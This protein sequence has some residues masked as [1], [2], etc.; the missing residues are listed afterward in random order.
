MIPRSQALEWLESLDAPIILAPPS[1]PGQIVQ[2][3]VPNNDG[4]EV[5]DRQDRLTGKTSRPTLMLDS[6]EIHYLWLVNDDCPQA[7]E[8]IRA[9][10]FLSCL[11]WGVDMAYADGQI[12]DDEQVSML[13]GVRWLP[14]PGTLRDDGLLRIPVGGSMID[15][16]RAHGSFLDRIEHGKP[17]RIVDKPQ[18]FDR[19][20]Y[21]SEERPL[22]RPFAVFAL[23]TIGDDSYRYAHAKL[24]HIAGMTRRA[25]I[26]A[27]KD[28][29]PANITD[30]AWV[31]TF[32]AGHR[33]AGSDNHQQF[34]YIP[35]P[36]I[37]HEHADAMIRRIM[38]MAPFGCETELRHLADQ[39][40]GVQLKPEGGGEGPVLDR[41][42]SDGVT[43]Q[44]LGSS[45]VWASVTPVILPG[46]DD[47]KPSKTVKLIQRALASERDRAGMRVHMERV[48]KF[49]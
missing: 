5:P 28:F 10:H 41:L 32:V 36:S 25:A 6:P 48:T 29:R 12:L 31:P 22:G 13:K 24:I 33:P 7:T 40:N 35:L 45:K 15:L 11:G 19:M 3:F 14:K 21:A 30:D 1:R 38:I 42:G 17:L 16:V 8:A 20:F 23:R 18:V 44:Y 39:L 43:R 47:H 4:D 37:G 27:M 26:D 49:Q 46:H 9:S 34:S 2:R